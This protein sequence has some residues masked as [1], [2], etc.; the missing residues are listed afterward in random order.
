[1]NCFY[2]LRCELAVGQNIT[3]E[4]LKINTADFYVELG[5]AQVINSFEEIFMNL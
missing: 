2:M 4:E 1:M 3:K 5:T